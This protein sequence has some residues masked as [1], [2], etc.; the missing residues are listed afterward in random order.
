M[1]N[2]HSLHN[3]VRSVMSS[4]ITVAQVLLD[5]SFIYIGG[6]IRVLLKQPHHATKN[7][8]SPKLTLKRKEEVTK[9]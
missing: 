2:T 8:R 4:V 1:I 5:S 7:K 9:S 6:T 3:I